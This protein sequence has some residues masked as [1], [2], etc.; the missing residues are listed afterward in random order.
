MNNCPLCDKPLKSG[1]RTG[2]D[3]YCPT[4][5]ECRG[6]AAYH[7]KYLPIEYVYVYPYRLMGGGG[8]DE[9]GNEM[10][11]VDVLKEGEHAIKWHYVC[12]LPKFPLGNEQQ[13]LKRLKMAVVFS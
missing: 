1:G 11:Q 8:T 4:Q 10:Y 6:K 13:L 7:Y 12:S 2:Q 5:V 3:V 9:F